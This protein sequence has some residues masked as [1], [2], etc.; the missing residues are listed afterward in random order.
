MTEKYLLGRLAEEAV[1]RKNEEETPDWFCPE[2]NAMCRKDCK[3]FVKAYA[4]GDVMTF[5]VSDFDCNNARL[6]GQREIMNVINIAE[7]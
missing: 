4:Y 2:I 3:C 6:T 1:K 7:R 5:Y